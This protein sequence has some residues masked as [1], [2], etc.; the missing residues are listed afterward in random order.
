MTTRVNQFLLE[1][2]T[3]RR[4]LRNTQSRLDDMQKTS[5]IAKDNDRA[6]SILFEI[7][8]SFSESSDCLT[9]GDCYHVFDLSPQA[10]P[11]TIR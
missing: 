1:N 2:G 11:Q 10:H 5:K 3:L 8:S 7:L 6:L 9:A 4:D